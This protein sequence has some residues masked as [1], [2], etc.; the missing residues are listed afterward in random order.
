MPADM[1]VIKQ[2][3]LPAIEI[4]DGFDRAWR[5]RRRGH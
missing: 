2:N 4:K 1:K 3:K 5:T